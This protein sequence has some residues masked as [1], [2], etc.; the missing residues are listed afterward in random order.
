MKDVNLSLFDRRN[1]EGYVGPYLKSFRSENGQLYVTDSTGQE[2]ALGQL[3]PKDAVNLVSVEVSPEGNLLATF[4]DERVIDL[5]YAN[6]NITTEYAEYQG[7]GIYSSDADDFKPVVIS[8]GTVEVADGTATLSKTIV[9]RDNLVDG[10]DLDALKTYAIKSTYEDRQDPSWYV[11]QT[12]IWDGTENGVIDLPAGNVLLLLNLPHI[13]AT[14]SNISI[15]DLST[16]EVLVS[17]LQESSNETFSGTDVNV[18]HSV[19]LT[20]PKQIVVKYVPQD[21]VLSTYPFGNYSGYPTEGSFTYGTI[22]VVKTTDLPLEVIDFLPVEG[23]PDRDPLLIEYFQNKDSIE[24][25]E[26]ENWFTETSYTSIAGV[27]GTDDYIYLIT[28]IGSVVIVNVATGEIRRASFKTHRAN[29]SWKVT[30][31]SLYAYTTSSDESNLKITGF[32]VEELPHLEF[33]NYFT[34]N[35]LGTHYADYVDGSVRIYDMNTYNEIANNSPSILQLEPLQITAYQDGWLVHYADAIYFFDVSSNLPQVFRGDG[36][37]NMLSSNGSLYS[38]TEVTLDKVVFPNDR[39]SPS[40]TGIYEYSA[41]KGDPRLALAGSNS[42]YGWRVDTRTAPVEDGAVILNLKSTEGPVRVNCVEIR[43]GSWSG[44]S[45]PSS[46]EVYGKLNDG[47]WELLYSSMGVWNTNEELCIFQNG[48]FEGTEFELRCYSD[49]G[50]FPWVNLNKVE[51]GLNNTYETHRYLPNL[52]SGQYDDITI[53]GPASISTGTLESLTSR[54]SLTDSYAASIA[55][56]PAVIEITLDKLTAITELAIVATLHNGTYMTNGVFSY[57]G[58]DGVWRA[59]IG[60]ITTSNQTTNAYNDDGHVYRS[61]V[62]LIYATK[63]RFTVNSVNSGTEFAL[64]QIIILSANR[65]RDLTVTR[66]AIELPTIQPYTGTETLPSIASY[67]TYRNPVVLPDRK[68]LEMDD[69]RITASHGPNNPNNHMAVLFNGADNT[70]YLTEAVD[71]DG[72]EV[73]TLDVTRVEGMMYFTEF[74]FSKPGSTTPGYQPTS[75][76]LLSSN[77]GETWDEEV[78]VDNIALTEIVIPMIPT[79][80]FVYAKYVR[81]RVNSVGA[82]GQVLIANLSATASNILPLESLEVPETILTLPAPTESEVGLGV[83]LSTEGVTA[84]TPEGNLYSIRAYLDFVNMESSAL[85]APSGSWRKYPTPAGVYN[86]LADFSA[87]NLSVGADN[88][89]V[90]DLRRLPID[91]SMSSGSYLYGVTGAW[92]SKGG[93]HW[94]TGYS[95]LGNYTLYCYD[96]HDDSMTVYDGLMFEYGGSSVSFLHPLADGKMLAVTNNDT[97]LEIAAEKSQ[98]Q[99]T[100]SEFM[101]GESQLY[102][103]VERKNL[104]N[105]TITEQGTRRSG[106]VND[107]FDGGYNGN[108][109]YS[110]YMRGI[111][112]FD[113]PHNVVAVAIETSSYLGYAADDILVE[114][115][116][117]GSTYT[118]VLDLRPDITVASAKYVF[119]FPEAMVIKALKFTAKRGS[120]YVELKRFYVLTTDMVNT[121]SEFKY[122]MT[123]HNALDR[124]KL[125]PNV[126]YNTAVVS[127]ETENVSDPNT[128]YNVI[129]PYESSSAA[130]WATSASTGDLSIILNYAEPKVA[131]KHINW[132]YSANKVSSVTIFGSNDGVTWDEIAQIAI[133]SDANAVAVPTEFENT[134]AY[135]SYKLTYS[136]GGS[137][138]AVYRMG[139]IMEDDIYDGDVLHGEDRYVGPR[140]NNSLIPLPDGKLLVTHQTSPSFNI[141]DAEGQIWDYPC[142]PLNLGTASVLD[143]YYLASDDTINIVLS[144]EKIA[145]FWPDGSS[146]YVNVQDYNASDRYLELPNYG[147]IR[148]RT[149]TTIRSL[150]DPVTSIVEPLSVTGLAGAEYDLKGKYAPDGKLYLYGASSTSNMY[151]SFDP[152]TFEHDRGT[153]FSRTYQNVA[154]TMTAKGELLHWN[155][156]AYSNL[157]YLRMGKI[158]FKGVDSISDEILMSRYVR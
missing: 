40:T 140:Y 48:I 83:N 56:G 9:S 55:D 152:E 67:V 78:T 59:T 106:Y 64:A 104:S 98:Y 4:D 36:L 82:H 46:F 118:Q 21:G 156:K 22:T 142:K 87:S 47:E 107:L 49:I 94:V 96:E 14:P 45:L 110:S 11:D 62:G 145:K 153:D 74:E 44:S 132:N 2:T 85:S 5:G 63:I 37:G 124:I 29:I 99:Y 148:Y 146:K 122:P 108:I 158:K 92:R 126:W 102:E 105:V 42:T 112:D 69:Y 76:T 93:Q 95:T 16:G 113:S 26:Y 65:Y 133:D 13:S 15:I 149:N 103:V 130:T 134:T 57:L 70:Q 73:F 54:H 12:L 23:L 3:L 101:L 151:H 138:V 141:I 17:T 52:T 8:E 143:G 116:V 90:G 68:L 50:A 139:L 24:L 33:G 32:T 10:I 7:E 155:T 53:T 38:F 147:V 71:F 30:N 91:I 157:S 1:V 58:T 60:L 6:D 123:Q 125:A 144:N 150:R 88:I 154:I 121:R 34:V 120:G 41:N 97:L 137:S 20:E 31:G 128:A 72:G 39:T 51:L 80:G 115:S 66:K 111:L 27:E 89:E 117:D 79:K 86:V 35:N 127:T 84:V 81:I 18:R 135:T 77:D 25:V 109:R 100:E 43:D 131:K 129:R 114:V 28:P 136:K 19:H 61:R 75:V 119:E